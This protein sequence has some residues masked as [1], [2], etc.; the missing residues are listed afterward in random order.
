MS[1]LTEFV[2]GFL[3]VIGLLTRPVAL[4]LSFNMIVAVVLKFSTGAGLGGASQ[5][6]EV[7][8]VFLSL[9]LIVEDCAN[10]GTAASQRPVA[11]ATAQPCATAFRPG[12]I[13]R[14]SVSR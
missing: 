5:A 2:G 11:T 6:I 14:F 7:G 8:I 13:A 4:F 10:A 9:I 3:I 1:A 12:F